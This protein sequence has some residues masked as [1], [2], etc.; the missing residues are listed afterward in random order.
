MSKF[1]KFFSTATVLS[2]LLLTAV[3]PA[4]AFDGRGGDTV[5]ISASEVINDDLYVGANEFVLDGTVNGD[6]ISGGQMLTINGTVNGN[7]IAAAQTIV[8]NGTIT[9][10]VLAGGSVLFFGENATIGGDVVGAGYS[11][12]FQKGGAIGRD[13]DAGRRADPA[14]RRRRAQCEGR[15]GSS[16]DRRQGRRRREGSGGRGRA[17]CRP[18]PRRRCSCRRARSLCRSSSRV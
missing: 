16:G 8:V 7:L 15:H 2:V 11:L 17:R 13:A 3:V 1:L 4:Y 9:G 14:G 12:E 10:D 5:T 6:V 18:D